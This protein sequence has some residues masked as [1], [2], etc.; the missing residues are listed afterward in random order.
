MEKNIRMIKDGKETAVK[1]LEGVA[2]VLVPTEVC[3]ALGIR[4]FAEFLEDEKKKNS[5]EE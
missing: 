5:K 2:E 4:T 3:Q 1:G